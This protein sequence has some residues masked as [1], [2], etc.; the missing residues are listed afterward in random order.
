MTKKPDEEDPIISAFEDD[1]DDQKRA[2]KQSSRWHWFMEILSALVRASVVAGVV[3]TGFQYVAS[4][5]REKTQRSFEL[6][7]L[8]E[9]DRIQEADEKLSG[10]LQ[11]L[12][13]EAS[14]LLGQGQNDPGFVQKFVAERLLEEAMSDK[15]LANSYNSIVYFLNRVSNCTT[16]QLCNPDVLNDFFKDYTR[17]FWD[18]FSENL[19][20]DAVRKVHPIEK[21]LNARKVCIISWCWIST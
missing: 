17:Q 8:W 14:A 21:Y 1:S 6:V 4:V 12:Q 13:D 3:F 19:K 11:Q 10:R 16:S 2:G 20:K 18:Y 5:G 15:E 7:D 9:S